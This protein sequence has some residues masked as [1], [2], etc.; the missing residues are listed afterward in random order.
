MAGK[1]EAQ[2]QQLFYNAFRGILFNT[3]VWADGGDIKLKYDFSCPEYRE[4]LEKY[5]IEEAAGKGGDFERA[6]RLCRWLHPRLKHKSDYDNHVPCN[7]LALLDYCFEKQDTGINCLNKAKILTE[8]CLALGIFA[9]RAY[10]Y[11]Y[12]PYDMDN[13]VVTEIYDRKRRAWLMLDPS[14]GTYLADK[15]GAPLS[16]VEARQKTAAGEKVTAVAER[17]SLK[18]I[19]ALFKRNIAEGYNPYYAKNMAYFAVDVVNK[20]GDGESSAYLVPAGFNLKEK[21]LQ[22]R[23]YRIEVMKELGNDEFAALM[24]KWYAEELTREYKTI[25]EATLL[26]PPEN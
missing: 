21:Q 8:C 25:S 20:F 6:L 22:N 24:E 5:P 16:L 19:P 18:D 13:H 7:S 14:M 3:Q 17:Q 11:P 12:S 15:E 9:R 4:L 23:R 10:M 1:K 2:N 26:A